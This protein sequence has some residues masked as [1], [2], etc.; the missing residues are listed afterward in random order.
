LRQAP[1]AHFFQDEA[2]WLAGIRLGFPL[3]ETRWAK[4]SE[5]LPAGPI[6][7]KMTGREGEPKFGSIDRDHSSSCFRGI[8]MSRTRILA[9][10][11]GLAAVVAVA[12]IGPL[13]IGATKTAAGPKLAHMV[14]F[15]LKDGSGANRAKLVASCKL[16]LSGH[17]GVEYFGT[18]S[19]AGDFNKEFNDRDFDVSL[20]LVFADKEAHDKYQESDR[21]Q[22]FIAEN[23]ENIEKVRVFDT[24]LSPAPPARSAVE[25]K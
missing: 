4:I 10:L 5:H 11:T 2:V 14:Y 7:A 25:S 1:W 19:L 3:E 15:K 20:H 22:K 18:G 23:L 16:L 13:G 9:T 24:Y 17:E 21:H 6:R 12:C 8:D